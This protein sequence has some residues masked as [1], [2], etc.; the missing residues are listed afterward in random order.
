MINVKKI[1]VGDVFQ[2]KAYDYPVHC[3]VMAITGD[4]VIITEYGNEPIV[5]LTSEINIFYAN[6]GDWEKE[7]LKASIS[8]IEESIKFDMRKLKQLRA[9]LE[10]L[11]DKKEYIKKLKSEW[12]QL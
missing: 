3:T 11:H 2:R 10:N 6:L 12:D 8:S 7:K 5:R 4:Y 1:K 9:T